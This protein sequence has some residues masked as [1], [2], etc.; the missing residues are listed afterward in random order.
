MRS[1]SSQSTY[2]CHGRSEADARRVGNSDQRHR[3]RRGWARRVWHHGCIGSS[4][5]FVVRAT[6]DFGP[7]R[8]GRLYIFSYAGAGETD[9]A[10]AE[11]L[12]VTYLYLEEV[13]PDV[14]NPMGF[15]QVGEPLQDPDREIVAT[16]YAT[17]EAA[18]RDAELLARR[19]GLPWKEVR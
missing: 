13:V 1:F 2:D 6:A 15:A 16:L 5:A 19:A 18:V 17:R 8:S 12:P 9:N 10:I 4:G 11:R 7:L 3:R 14:T